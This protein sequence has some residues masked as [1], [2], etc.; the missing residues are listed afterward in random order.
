MANFLIKRQV[1]GLI[2]TDWKIYSYNSW[3]ALFTYLDNQDEFLPL[4]I[5]IQDNF[6]N[7]NSNGSLFAVEYLDGL[8]RSG[9]VIKAESLSSV[10][11]YLIGLGYSIL[12]ISKMK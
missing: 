9:G 6:I 2:E 7:L 10:N 3:A 8:N 1:T 12:N 5:S 4:E 11:N